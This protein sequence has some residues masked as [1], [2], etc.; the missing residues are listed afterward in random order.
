MKSKHT[1][2]KAGSGKLKCQEC[3]QECSQVE[4][5]HGLNLCHHLALDAVALKLKKI[6]GRRQGLGAISATAEAQKVEAPHCPR[7]RGL[8]VTERYVDWESNNDFEGWRCFACGNVWDGVIADN[9]ISVD[10]RIEPH[11]PIRPSR[12]MVQPMSVRPLSGIQKE[13]TRQER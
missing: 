4:F 5:H 2:K 6:N 9:R 11:L 12:H 13:S 3:G 1:S 7:C 8:M 10:K